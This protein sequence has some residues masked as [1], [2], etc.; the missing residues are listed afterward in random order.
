MNLLSEPVGFLKISKICKTI[1]QFDLFYNKIGLV[2]NY[3][4]EKIIKFK[5]GLFKDYFFQGGFI[6]KNLY[7]WFSNYN[8]KNL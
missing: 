7:Q 2:L 5:G 3:M 4:Y 1:D 6:T 8:L